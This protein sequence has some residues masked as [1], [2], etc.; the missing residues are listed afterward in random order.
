MDREELKRKDWGT[1]SASEVIE[2]LSKQLL[3]SEQNENLKKIIT[4]PIYSFLK[5][6]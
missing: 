2:L 4:D 1:E 6:E 3:N 5:A